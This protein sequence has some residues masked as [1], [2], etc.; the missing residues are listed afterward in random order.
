M[1]HNKAAKQTL[2]LNHE[3]KNIDKETVTLQDPNQKILGQVWMLV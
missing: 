3:S 2:F 1:I